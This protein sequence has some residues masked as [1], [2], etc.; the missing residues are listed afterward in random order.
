MMA[1]KTFI[2]RMVSENNSIART[3]YERI[4]RI[5]NGDYNRLSF[6]SRS[7]AYREAKKL[8]MHV[9]YFEN[10]YFVVSED[11]LGKLIYFRYWNKKS[12]NEI[13]KAPIIEE[14]IK[15]RQ[16]RRLSQK[17]LGELSGVKQSMIERIEKG[18]TNPQID[19]LLKI[20]APLGKTLA[21]VPLEK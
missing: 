14:M 9:F 15:A 4:Y 16:G 10:S 7:K 3:C 19:T 8:G 5:I 11:E 18:V 12:I 17:K 2:A 6:D 13:E 20:L 1:K 21:V